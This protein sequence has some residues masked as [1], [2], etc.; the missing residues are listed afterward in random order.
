MDIHIY[1]YIFST[2]KQGIILLLADEPLMIPFEV[3]VSALVAEAKGEGEVGVCLGGAL[4]PSVDRSL[5][6]QRERLPRA[7]RV[8][9][10]TSGAAAATLTA[11]RTVIIS[12][13]LAARTTFPLSRASLNN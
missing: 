11:S 3:G 10:S 6:R 12:S 13:Y 9:R 4:S 1:I 8:A 5:P 2:R 7:P